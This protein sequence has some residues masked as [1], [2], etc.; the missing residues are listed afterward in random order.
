MVTSEM[1]DDPEKHLRSIHICA[2]H[3]LKVCIEQKLAFCNGVA[4]NSLNCQIQSQNNRMEESLQLFELV[5]DCQRLRNG[6]LHE[7]VASALY[8]VGIANLRL[9]RTTTAL[10][11]FEE[12]VRIRKGSL[13]KDHP[14]VAVSCPWPSEFDCVL[15]TRRFGSHRYP[16]IRRGLSSGLIGQGRNHPVAATTF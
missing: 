15:F 5:V 3:Y 13:G 9:E 8:N 2:V 1:L 14:L 6:A 12:S 10:Q 16:I 4:L 7:D 11:A